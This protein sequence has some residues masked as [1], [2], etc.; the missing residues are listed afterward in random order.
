MDL[1]RRDL[2]RGAGARGVGLALPATAAAWAAPPL[3]KGLDGPF[4]HGVAS[5]DPDTSSVVLWTRVDGLS[6]TG[7]TSVGWEVSTTPDMSKVVR[8][9]TTTTSSDRDGTVRII[10]TG[11]QAGSS[12]FYRFST[13]EGTSPVGRSNSGPG[14]PTRGW[15]LP[16]PGCG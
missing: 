3:P 9:G 13:T 16:G 1:T 2:F 10:A 4:R 6:G 15:R 12:Y 11:L 8:S 7:S 5:G 14:K